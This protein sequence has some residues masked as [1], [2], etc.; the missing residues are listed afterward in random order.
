MQSTRKTT[1][2]K[3]GDQTIQLFDEEWKDTLSE[4]EKTL[5]KET[6]KRPSE[7]HKEFFE[8]HREQ[9]A[10]N[11]RLSIAWEK[12]IYRNQKTYSNFLTGVFESVLTLRK[13]FEKSN[14]NSGISI[15]ISI[16]NGDKKSHWVD[17]NTRVMRY[18]SIRYR[19]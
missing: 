16:V 5:L 17:K 2:G 7:D 19:G 12:W 6:P 18:F 14:E 15:S 13:Q 3:L 10:E 11:R 8:G 4:D 1:S 9:I